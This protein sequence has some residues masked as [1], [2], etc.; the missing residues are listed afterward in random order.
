MTFILDCEL[1]DTFGGEANY[2]W[3]RRAEAELSDGA[4]DRAIVRAGKAALGLTGC[5]CRTFNHGDQWELRPA[6]SLTVAFLT[7]RCS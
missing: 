7:V 1:T 3:V 2:S 6:G 4:T 5:R